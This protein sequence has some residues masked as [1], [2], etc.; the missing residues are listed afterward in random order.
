MDFIVT[1]PLSCIVHN[2]LKHPS[3]AGSIW[4]SLSLLVLL[5]AIVAVG[6]VG[7]LL[8]NDA[9]GSPEQLQQLL[10]SHQLPPAPVETTTPDPLRPTVIISPALKEDTAQ[11]ETKLISPLRAYYATKSER[12][13]TITVDQATSDEHTAQ[14]TFELI[15]GGN[16]TQ[17]TFYYDRQGPDKNG[18]YPTWEP[19]LLDKTN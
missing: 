16:A 1:H 10:T 2:M 5:A 11:L 19:S 15:S 14:V 17:H 13:G 6:G 12:L 18:N 4:I 9:D 3:E 7:W 8:W